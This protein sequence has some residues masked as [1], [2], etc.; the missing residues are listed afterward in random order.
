[1]T[2][3]IIVALLSGLFLFSA[4]Y[5]DTEILNRLDQLE[6]TTISNI[7]R[8]FDAVKA[9]ISS[10][11]TMDSSLKELITK[12]QSDGAASAKDI[13][14]LKAYDESLEEKIK[15]LKVYVLAQDGELVDWV[16]TTYCTI[17]KYNAIVEE[18]TELQTKFGALS[19]E[20]N[21]K[22]ETSAANIKTWVNEALASYTKKEET[23]ALA[24][25]L[26]A[27][28]TKVDALSA[29]ITKL[30]ER[31]QSIVFVPDYS[32]GFATVG[33]G[34]KGKGYTYEESAISFRIRPADAAA[35]LAAKKENLKLQALYTVTRSAASDVE[36]TITSASAQDDVLTLYFTGEDLK[37][38][39]YK[40]EEGASVCLMISDG[41]NDLTSE[42]VKLLAVEEASIS[43]PS[44]ISIALGGTAKLEAEVSPAGSKVKWTSRNEK[45]VKVDQEGNLTAVE[46]GKAT[47]TATI[48][49]TT[50]S[51]NCIVTVL[52]AVKV[53]SISFD[54]ETCQLM[55]GQK[56]T[57]TVTFN[58]ATA[59][60]KNVSWFTSN[61]K[62]V[63]VV[64][65]V[66]VANGVGEAS[67]IAIS[68]DGAKQA[69]CDY[70]VIVNPDYKQ[71]ISV[72][73]NKVAA[74]I[75][76]NHYI[77]LVATVN[78]E[79]ATNKNVTWTSSD[80]TIAKVENGKV[81]GLKAGTATIT[82][83]TEDGEKTA[84]CE[85][86]VGEA[87]TEYEYVDLGLESGTKWATMNIGAADQYEVGTYF[88]WGALSAN[89]RGIYSRDSYKQVPAAARYNN[90]DRMTL[91][92]VSDDAA[93]Q[94]WGIYWRV[95][96]PGEWQELI[97]NCTIKYDKDNG[98]Y[99]LTS[100]IKGYEDQTIF[101]PAGGY[102]QDGNLKFP[103]RATYWANEICN[104]QLVGYAYESAYSVF[105][106]KD[107][108]TYMVSNNLRYLGL[109]IRP[110]YVPNP[111]V[112]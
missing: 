72:S 107:A 60:N 17:E 24:D 87:T 5:D 28:S 82:V 12:L 92:A 96:T 78:P 9:S 37:D 98:G 3:R 4:C 65:G 7:N 50:K 55:V 77:T 2:K 25:Q 21:S 81:T 46:E 105:M 63:T 70:K 67:I 75:W 35:K 32:D 97:A 101:L 54:K 22:I 6:G 95:P 58:P 69:K 34:R 91:L 71:V 94:I 84:K 1:M 59:S 53:E 88:Q 51:A 39:F 109:P 27:L 103:V 85:V 93:K 15:D 100:K 44:Q 74:T 11:E 41:N 18:M 19:E 10:L 42:Y 76:V 79:D 26:K 111:V 47:V 73:L 86:T 49:G 56:D 20:L 62:V 108:S 52:P 45:V 38:D 40:G 106:S 23:S 29:D 64:K 104:S 36:L 83:T 80:P 89:A 43:I 48:V 99:L 102:M 33:F 61:E 30:M 57:L 31:I 14:A 110:V 16:K 112:L 66:V 68:E 13:T 8:E 90:E